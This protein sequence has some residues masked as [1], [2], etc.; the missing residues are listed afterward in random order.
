MEAS[1]KGHG[2]PFCGRRL[3]GACVDAVWVL[4]VGCG[5]VWQATIMESDGVTLIQSGWEKHK[6]AESV[7]LWRL[8]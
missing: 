5:R 7:R 4:T 2:L 1:A 6:S 8:V 3:L